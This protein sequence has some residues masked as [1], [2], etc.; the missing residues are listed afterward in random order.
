MISGW[1]MVLSMDLVR[2]RRGENDGFAPLSNQP[3]LRTDVLIGMGPEGA[4]CT[5][6]SRASRRRTMRPRP[7]SNS[8]ADVIAAA[9]PMTPINKPKHALNNK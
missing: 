3:K 8:T 5:R 2:P 1:T 6:S 4:E 9:P 7:A